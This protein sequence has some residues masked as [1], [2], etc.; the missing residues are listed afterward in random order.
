MFHSIPVNLFPIYETPSAPR[1][2]IICPVTLIAGELNDY[3]TRVNQRYMTFAPENFT[4]WLIP[5]VGHVAGLAAI[6][7]EYT[8]RMIAF[9]DAALSP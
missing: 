6:P 4:L 5:N 8:A 1:I 2:V 3:E 9:F 7:D